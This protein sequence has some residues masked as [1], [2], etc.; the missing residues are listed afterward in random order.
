MVIM[1]VGRTDRRAVAVQLKEDSLQWSD[2][3]YWA[4]SLANDNN[5]LHTNTSGQKLGCTLVSLTVIDVTPMT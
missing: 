1:G 2:R 5:M 4:H 3:Y